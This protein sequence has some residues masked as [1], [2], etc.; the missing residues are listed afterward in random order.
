MRMKFTNL[1]NCTPT[2]LHEGILPTLPSVNKSL[3]DTMSKFEKRLFAVYKGPA[4][5]A[6]VLVASEGFQR[7]VL[8]SKYLYS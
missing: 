7:W 3:F 4:S 6:I 5:I 1:I 8:Y 2:H